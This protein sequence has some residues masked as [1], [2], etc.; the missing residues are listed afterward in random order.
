MHTLCPPSSSRYCPKILTPSTHFSTSPLQQFLFWFIAPSLFHPFP[1][2]FPNFTVSHY[3]LFATCSPIYFIAPPRPVI[4]PSSLPSSFRS[5][6]YA[7]I[8]S[9]GNKSPRSSLH[10]R[11]SFLSYIREEG[12]RRRKKTRCSRN[13]WLGEMRNVVW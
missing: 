13:P 9:A 6:K 12:R 3:L 8:R 11:D 4:P 10:D 1:S 2:P 7:P 5:L